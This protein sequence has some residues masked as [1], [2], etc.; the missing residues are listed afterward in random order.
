[1]WVGL[2]RSI[3]WGVSVV[4]VVVVVLLLPLPLLPS[5]DVDRP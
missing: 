5:L 4:V 2:Y 1:M 3:V